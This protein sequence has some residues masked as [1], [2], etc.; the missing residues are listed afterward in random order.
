MS[1]D[2]VTMPT[3]RAA[4]DLPILAVTDEGLGNTS[5]VLERP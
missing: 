3:R 2:D 1:D 4:D 5:W